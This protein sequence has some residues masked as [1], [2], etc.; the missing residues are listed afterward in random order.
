IKCVNCAH[1]VMMTRREFEKKLK[2]IL[3]KNSEKE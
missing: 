2:K 1:I 3:E